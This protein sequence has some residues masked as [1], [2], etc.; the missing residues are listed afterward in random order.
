MTDE[1]VKEYNALAEKRDAYRQFLCDIKDMCTIKHKEDEKIRNR[2]ASQ[3]KSGT[4]GYTGESFLKFF[5]SL[6]F[7][8][9][10]DT[11]NYEMCIAP[12][13]EFG[14]GESLEIDEEA[15]LFIA[16][17]LEQRLAAIEKQIEEL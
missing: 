13:Y 7:R 3:N 11:N 4:H 1:Q 9:N 12:H 10:K 14:R 5:A 8:I 6:G 2:I 17:Y 15:V 16:A